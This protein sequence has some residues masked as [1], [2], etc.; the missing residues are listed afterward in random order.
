MR[1]TR[2]ARSSGGNAEKIGESP[3]W[4]ASRCVSTLGDE[5]LQPGTDLADEPLRRLAVEGRA[6][7]EDEATHARAPVFRELSRPG[8]H[9][10]RARQR[11]GGRGARG[12]P[13]ALLEL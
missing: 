9:G 10:V 8:L 3:R 11:P 12:E 13:V 1:A 5:L 4:S 7:A 6:H 2:A